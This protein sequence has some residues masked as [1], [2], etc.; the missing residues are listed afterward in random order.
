MN[1]F[2]YKTSIRETFLSSLSELT[3]ILRISSFYTNTCK[4][5]KRTRK[6]NMCPVLNITPTLGYLSHS[7]NNFVLYSLKGPHQ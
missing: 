4:N 5:L 6:F 2:L 3:S 7:I 1:N